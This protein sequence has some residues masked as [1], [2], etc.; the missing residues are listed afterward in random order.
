ME[1]KNVK[2]RFRNEVEHLLHTVSDETLYDSYEKLENIV[3]SY[4]G[5]LSKNDVY[6]VFIAIENAIPL[7][8]SQE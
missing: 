7:N 6:E 5:Q 8:L 4:K 1:K 3:L 2:E